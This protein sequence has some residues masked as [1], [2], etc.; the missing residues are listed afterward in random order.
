M[1]EQWVRLGMALVIIAL[2]SACLYHFSGRAGAS[3]PSVTG[4]TFKR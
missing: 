4:L 1:T 3:E 2:I